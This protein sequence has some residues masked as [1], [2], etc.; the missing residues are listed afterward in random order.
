MMFWDNVS[1]MGILYCIY[2]IIAILVMVKVVLNNRDTFKTLAWMLV[3]LFLP[4]FG[5]VLYFFFGR[6]TRRK[7]I[8]GGRMLNQIQ[9]R[10]QLCAT[11]GDTMDVSS[12]YEPLVSFFE[13]S[14]S[15]SLA[16]A[17]SVKAL[18]SMHEFARMLLEEIEGAKEHVHV[19]FYIFED[20]CFGNKLRDALI[21]KARQGVEVRVIYDSVGCWNVK[22]EFFEGMR[23]AGVY[24][25]SFLRVRFPLFTNKVNYRNHRKVVVID[26]KVGFVGGCNIADRYL[27]GCAWGK[28]RDTMLFVK[29]TAVHGLQASF[30]VDWYF[31]N[32]T[33][34][35]GKRYFP[36]S[37]AGVGPLM[38][39]VQSNP[40]GDVRTIMIGF[41]KALATARNYVYLQTPYFMPDESF[42]QA[43]KGAALSGVDVRIMIPERSDSR[44]TDYAARSYFKDLLKSGVKIYLYKG[45]MLHCKTFICDDALSSVGSVNLDFRSFYYNFEVS[46]FVYGKDVATTLKS[47][48]LEDAKECRILSMGEINGR[49]FKERCLESFSR[50]FSPL[51]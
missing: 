23:C 29:G 10:R 51:L 12:E 5:L 26:G 31:S 6:D 30:L 20:D 44:I 34:V 32:R 41:I 45:G 17:E 22:R 50:L 38:Q 11:E 25:E 47:D 9:Q 33:L 14:A 2:C 28:W 46:A 16:S 19:Q 43:L 49:S 7:K 48:F 8:I 18:S 36:I 27:E 39:V 37:Q 24:V 15:A 13:N 4:F 42:V 40:V 35:S 3:F 1:V 21:A